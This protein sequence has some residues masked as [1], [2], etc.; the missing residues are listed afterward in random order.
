MHALAGNRTPSE[1]NLKTRR[2][3][4][5]IARD[6]TGNPECDAYTRPLLSWRAVGGPDLTGTVLDD[7]YQI[8]ERIAEGAMG[9]VYRG[10]RLK[11]DRAVAIKVMHSALPGAMEGRKRFEREAKLMARLEH[12]HCVSII[13]FGLHTTAKPYVVMELVRGRDLH[14]LLVEQGRFEIPR[15][16]EV[17][18]QVLSGLQHAHEQGIIHRDIKPANIMVTPKAPLGLHVRILDFGLARM[19]EAT[20]SVSNGVAVGTPSYMAPEQCRGDAI[21]S[22]V[23][24][25]ACGIVLFEM[26]TGE[27]PFRASDP[28]AIIKK[29]IE[30]EPPRLAD[31]APGDYGALEG[32]V[33]R[34]LAKSPLDRFPSAVAMAEALDAAVSGRVASEPTMQ[35]APVR[36]DT[37]LRASPI[38]E[39][40]AQRSAKPDSSVDV[41]ITVGSTVLTPAVRDSGNNSSVRREL[42]VSRKP[43]L[44]LFLI[45]LAGA[46]LGAV[47][48]WQHELATEEPADVAPAPA[49]VVVTEPPPPDVLPPDPATDLAAQAASLA[50]DGKEETAIDMLVKARKV[51]PEHVGLA[52]TLGKLYFG[53]L[54]W[55]DG[56][57]NLRDAIKLEP[58][59]KDDPELQKLA[60]RAFNTTPRYDHRL[61]S[62]VLELGPGVAPLLEETAREHRNPNTRARAQSLL[63]RLSR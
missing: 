58:S 45:V 51:Y 55:N 25:Y 23:D 62:F 52:V 31:V 9:A 34:A 5:R 57:T 6:T 29:Q 39:S 3:V 4:P 11:L 41:P 30:E 36:A 26:L 38:S 59:L 28:I 14:E 18:R 2:T 33:A 35:L 20:T 12:P 22:R 37:T 10:V 15:A 46:G 54:W 50:A 60:V 40:A 32:V 8:L 13:D 63:R 27:K 42:P 61:A 1:R 24:I 7:R 21:D 53:K 49:P 43:W 44:V 48:M 17:M 16:I 47:I 19:L 56:L